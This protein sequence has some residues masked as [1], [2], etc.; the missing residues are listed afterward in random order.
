MIIPHASNTS[1]H[2][3]HRPDLLFASGGDYSTPGTP[4]PNQ[5]FFNTGGPGLRFQDVTSQVL[6][7]VKQDFTGL[8]RTLARHKIVCRVYS[9]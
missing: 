2:A 1:G 4:E 5:V 9:D 8:G 3:A 6:G 7:N